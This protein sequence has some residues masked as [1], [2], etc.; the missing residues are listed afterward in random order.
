VVIE[1]GCSVDECIVT[2]GV[3]IQ[4]GSAYRRSVLRATASGVEVTPFDV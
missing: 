1:E 2:D 3:R 4:S